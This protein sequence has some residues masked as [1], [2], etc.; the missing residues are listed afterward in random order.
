MASCTDSSNKDQL[1]RLC[2]NLLFLRFTGVQPLMVAIMRQCTKANVTP[3]PSYKS[4]S[5][6]Q[7]WPGTSG[8]TSKSHCRK[9]EAAPPIAPL[10]PLTCS[11]PGKLLHIDFTSILETVPL[12]QEL[13]VRN[14]IVMQDHFSKYV[15]A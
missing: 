3:Y 1:R 12:L 13:V 2:S 6:G 14:V 8:I 11:G 15:V 4:N 10:K 7:V 5:G 9:F